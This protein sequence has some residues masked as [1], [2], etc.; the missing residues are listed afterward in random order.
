MYHS[1]GLRGAL[2]DVMKEK[3]GSLEDLKIKITAFTYHVR[4]ATMSLQNFFV[5]SSCAERDCDV[6]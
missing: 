3:P 5:E 1:S 2:T 6:A 4:M